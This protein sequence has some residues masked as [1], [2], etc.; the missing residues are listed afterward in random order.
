VRGWYLPQTR[1]TGGKLFLQAPSEAEAQCC[2]MC[3]ADLVY[4]VA[5][6]DMDALTF[7]TPRLIRHLMAPGN[8]QKLTIDEFD[9]P[10]VLEHMELTQVAHHALVPPH[11]SLH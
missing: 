10:L 5:T 2:A 9:F 6:D 3:K 4:G 8:N 11:C 7:G 1:L